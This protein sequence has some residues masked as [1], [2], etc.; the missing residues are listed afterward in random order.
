MS[1][2]IERVARAINEAGYAHTGEM[3]HAFFEELSPREQSL[4]RAMARSAIE[5]MREPTQEML[6]ASGAGRTQKA[7]YTA[8][9]GE[10]LR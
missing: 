6:M 1:E 3:P 8:M 5:A 10:A 4:L 7:K 9:I 2:M